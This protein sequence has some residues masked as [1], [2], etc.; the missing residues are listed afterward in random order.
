MMCLFF[1][2]LF[3][4]GVGG[5]CSCGFFQ[6]RQITCCTRGGWW[7]VWALSRSISGVSDDFSTISLRLKREQAR[8]L[9][10][11]S[12]KFSHLIV[13]SHAGCKVSM[14]AQHAREPIVIAMSLF[15]WNPTLCLF[16]V[17][18]VQLRQNSHWQDHHTRRGLCR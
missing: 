15:F 1:G 4:L 16:V 8:P 17:C 10:S 7:A 6:F 3:W 5:R 2:A 9:L 11:F 12:E 14:F 13:L 18:L